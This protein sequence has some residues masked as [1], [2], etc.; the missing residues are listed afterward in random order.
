MNSQKKIIIFGT[1][2]SGKSTLIK[3]LDNHPDINVIHTHDCLI[4]P[5]Y[6]NSKKFWDNLEKK[7]L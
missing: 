4:N 7:K 2:H 6:K 5:F 1:G 3:L